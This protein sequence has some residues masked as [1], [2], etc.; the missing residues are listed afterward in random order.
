MFLIVLLRAE[1]EEAHVEA[2][3]ASARS[4]QVRLEVCGRDYAKQ[5]IRHKL[6]CTCVFVF[7]HLWGPQCFTIR[8]EDLCCNEDIWDYF[9]LYGVISEG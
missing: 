5:I 7:V 4:V 8:Y 3:S 6:F 2:S 9:N 1:A